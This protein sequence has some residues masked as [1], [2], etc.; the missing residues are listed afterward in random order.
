[1]PLKIQ[2]RCTV[3][4]IAFFSLLSLISCCF[5]SFWLSLSCCWFSFKFLKAWKT[6]HGYEWKTKLFGTYG[7]KE[8]LCHCV[9]GLEGALV[10]SL[11]G[12]A[13]SW[14]LSLCKFPAVL[15]KVFD[16]YIRQ[17]L[18]LTLITALYC[19]CLLVCWGGWGVSH[20]SSLLPPAPTLW[21]QGQPGTDAAAN[22]FVT[23]EG[24]RTTGL[25][26]TSVGAS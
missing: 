21:P 24:L 19:F 9:P 14:L 3:F 4:K 20:L 17:R 11:G 12:Q 15:G 5:G 13:G 1:M 16:L 10:Q 8:T 2:V 26:N 18:F 22:I 7:T 6:F 25:D 23:Q